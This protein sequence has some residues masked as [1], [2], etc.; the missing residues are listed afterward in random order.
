MS[1]LRVMGKNCVEI[2]YKI[3]S[4]DNEYNT[5]GVTFEIEFTTK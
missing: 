4:S 1:V 2:P 3:F 5:L